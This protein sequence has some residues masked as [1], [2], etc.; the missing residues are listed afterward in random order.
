VKP[1]HASHT[2]KTEDDTKNGFDFLGF[3]VRQYPSSMRT[4]KYVTLIKPNR[5]GQ[6]RHRKTMEN[7]L[8][9]GKAAAQENVIKQLNPII[10]GWSN[11]YRAVVSSKAF[12]R[13]DHFLFQKLWKWCLRRHPDKGLRW[14][15]RKYFRRYKGNNWCFAASDS[16]RLT[17]HCDTH[18][19]R[20]VKIQETKTPYDGN[21]SYWQKRPGKNSS[22]HDLAS[23]CV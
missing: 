6:K 16:V 11:Y 1:K 7:A 4:R 3:S 2:L 10:R 17:R 19:K 23:R 12:N 9:P 22:I 8:K 15:K 13:M 20:H 18:I 21:I 5:E 14:I